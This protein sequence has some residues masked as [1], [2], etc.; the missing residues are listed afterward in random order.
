MQ[1]GLREQGGLQMSKVYYEINYYSPTEDRKEVEKDLRKA[2]N[3]FLFDNRKITGF[4]LK[5]LDF[6]YKDDD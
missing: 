1:R 2:I 6:L 4:S 3:N 5:R